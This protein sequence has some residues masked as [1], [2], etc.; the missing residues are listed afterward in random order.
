MNETVVRSCIHIPKSKLSQQELD[1]YRQALTVVALGFKNNPGAVVAAYNET[2]THL[3]VPR[4]FRNHELWPLADRFDWVAP[5]MAYRLDSKMTLDPTRG[6]V[7]AADA[8]TAHLNQHSGGILVAPTGTGKT[9]LALETAR[10]FRTPIG[11]LI[12]AGHMIENWMRHCQE[13]FGLSADDVSV[14]QSD[15][16]ALDKPVT[17]M[18]VQSLLSRSYPSS[19]YEQIGFLIGDEVHR[20]GAAEWHKVISMFPARYR[21]GMSADPCRPDG[22]GSVVSWSFGDMA[23]RLHRRDRTKAT[24]CLYRYPANYRDRSYCDFVREGN[25]WV[26]GDPNPLKYDRLL[27]GDMSRNNW[28]VDQ[29]IQARQK[30]RCILVFAKHRQHLHLLHSEF[31]KRLAT[32]QLLPPT[33]SALLLGGATTKKAKAYNSEA[34][35]ADVIFSTYSYAKDAMDAVQLDTLVFATP[36]GNPLQPIGRLRDINAAE[37]Q[38]L[39][40]IDVYEPNDY[41]RDRL[42]RRESLYTRLGH[43]VRR[44]GRET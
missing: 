17:I 36:P 13:H 14:V 7:A 30:G 32:N 29:I 9:L 8:L 40:V 11:V 28:L 31:E 39:L 16:C 26:Q 25:Q 18:F 20:Y 24:V 35:K 21:L 41:A 4:Y 37:K 42:S 38:P 5:Y 10:R 19:L 23:Y 15:K 22:L 1:S 12:Y 34:I 33:K 44:F 43:P 6:Q 27:M 3:V 2:D